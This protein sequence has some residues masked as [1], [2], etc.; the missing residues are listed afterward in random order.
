MLETYVLNKDD[1]LETALSDDEL[2][3]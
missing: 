1:V 3:T 2:Q